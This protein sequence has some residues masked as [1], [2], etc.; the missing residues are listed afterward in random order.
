MRNRHQYVVMAYYPEDGTFFLGTF[1]HDRTDYMCFEGL[2]QA[3]KFSSKHAAEVAAAQMKKAALKAKMDPVYDGPRC[4]IR[5]LSEML[6][7]KG[8]KKARQKMLTHNG[9]FRA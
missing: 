9:R 8:R 4:R 2:Q 1:K 6:M 5:T 3:T 7:L